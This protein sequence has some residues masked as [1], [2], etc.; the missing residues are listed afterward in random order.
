MSAEAE[1][2]QVSASVQPKPLKVAIIG[3]APSSRGL[4]PYADESWEIWTLADLVLC[5]QVP[6]FSRHFEMHPVSW[7]KGNN[8]AYWQWLLQVTDKPVYVTE[9]DPEMP[10]ATIYPKA[11]VLGG[12][13]SK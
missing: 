9:L 10:T 2:V 5:K 1:S 8:N 7:F 3:K 13:D 11:K 6:R 4:A 12:T